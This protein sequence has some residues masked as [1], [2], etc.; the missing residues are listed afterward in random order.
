M[1]NANIFDATQTQM[2]AI[3]LGV[4]AAQAPGF[5]KA[6]TDAQEK[7]LIKRHVMF[8]KQYLDGVNSLSPFDVEASGA[9]KFD[10]NFLA[11]TMP[12]N[13]AFVVA[14]LQLQTANHATASTAGMHQLVF[15]SPTNAGFLSSLV[16][17]EIAGK[18]ILDNQ[19]V[20]GLID[21]G[22]DIPD[23]V[24]F[25]ELRVWQENTEINLLHQFPV[26]YTPAANHDYVLYSLHGF[27]VERA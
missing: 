14:G 24:R 12:Q 7:V 11:R 13:K 15:V 4:L 26:A 5:I 18:K 9:A 10:S 2:R 21:N 20:A 1:N 19:R 16:T 17:L 8:N 25:P 3:I 22:D 27:L 6:A 23:Y